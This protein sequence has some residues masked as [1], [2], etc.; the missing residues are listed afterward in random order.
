[1]MY[2]YRPKKGFAHVS[3]TGT[4]CRLNCLHCKG[5]FLRGMEGITD[6]EV[7]YLKAMDMN[8]ENCIGILVSGGSDENGKVPLDGFIPILKRIKEDTRLLINVHT[9]IADTDTAVKLSH[10]GVDTVSYDIIGSQRTLD[11][12]YGLDI[13]PDEVMTGYREM[14]SR[15]LRVIPHITVGLHEGV[16]EGEFRA[17]DMIRD[18]DIVVINSLIPSD[19]FGHTVEQDDVLSVVEYALGKKMKVVMGC[20][21]ERGNHGMEISAM[22]MGISGMVMPSRI[23]VKWAMENTRVLWKDGCC[24]IYW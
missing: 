9:G 1:M 21:R 13:G 11:H 8:R 4:G 5:R 16:L 3:V 17:V 12:V 20:M 10:A 7:L 15:G 19:S 6:P 14:V 18:S 2:F 23:A 24:A 22:E